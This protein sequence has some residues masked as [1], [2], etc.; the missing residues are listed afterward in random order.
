LVREELLTTTSKLGQ[1]ELHRRLFSGFPI[2][3]G[4]RDAVVAS[5]M[6]GHHL[7]ILG[8]PGSGKTTL[9]QRIASLLGDTP[10]VKGCPVNC[11]P[12]ISECPWCQEALARGETLS[13]EVLPH[14]QRIKRLQGS[15]D[16]VP[17]DLVGDLDPEVAFREG[18]HSLTA[19]V[20]G[21]LLRANRGILLIDFVDRMPERV[22]NVVLTALAGDN[23]SIGPFEEHFPMDMVVIA[24]GSQA[25]LHYL[26]LDLVD[27]FDVVSLG[28]IPDR[29]AETAVVAASMEKAGK[30]LPAVDTAQVVDIT[31]LTRSHP[32]VERG[33]ST[34]G[35]IRYA[36]V[37]SAY[38]ELG[39]QGEVPLRAAAHM[40][41][42]HRL[43]VNLE[44]DLPGKRE[45]VV[46]EVLE[47]VLGEESEDGLD[48]S[49]T[50]ED[51]L[52]LVEELAREDRFRK[53][54]KY[55]AF[56]LLL[57]R[58]HRFPDSRLARVYQDV[59]QRLQELYPDRFHPDN[60][61]EE[62]LA[63]IEETRMR[64]ERMVRALREMESEALQQTLELLQEHQV[65]EKGSRGWEISRRGIAFLLEKLT[66]RVW[67]SV[68]SSGYG[69]HATGK[70]L[71]AGEGRV[72][73]I[74]QYRFG[75][76][77][78][79]ISLKDT[80]RR[81]IRNRHEGVTREDIMVT[82]KD[83]RAKMDIILVV[84]LS[85]TMRQLE[86]LWYAKE[87]AIA[88]SLA[89]A[90]SGDRVGVVT[91]SNMADVKVDVTT[92]PHR[93]CGKV[94]DLEL[95]E[96][97][98]TNIGYGLLKATHLFDRHRGGRAT[99]HLILISDGDATAPHPSPQK[100]ALRQAARAARKGIT[101]SCICIHEESA[102]PELM[103][104]IAR[105]GKGRT[106][107]IGAEGITDAVLQERLAARSAGA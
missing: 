57:K 37:L 85:G 62:L 10:V 75:D 23:I 63:E 91:F 107:V 96:K 4:E 6:S 31:G 66:P 74:R 52:G 32:E 71:T 24:T 81:A 25:G 100:Y 56:D 84:D 48:I 55:G 106:Y 86:K 99:R 27:C 2:A 34:R 18:L 14:P 3:E 87:S 50:K 98:F 13:Q 79:D 101:I 9:A 36:E 80:M 20:P 93:V 102:D 97:A 21:K 17:E 46:D 68:Y 69:R 73:G 95:H 47:E 26:P 53:P 30:N 65:L 64:E 1:A 44:T 43:R 35:A 89:A 16:L 40:S 83:I 5:I 104:R 54:L 59:Y 51:L 49:L 41:L 29:E 28:Y 11:S 92:N 22:L 58:I 105:I 88:L 39:T 72:V 33:V 60:I 70:K 78:K 42:P 90:Q 12:E 8:P 7:L 76:R 94:I 61:T 67:E 82:T 45:M 77:Y 103:R 19:F 38:Q 15:G